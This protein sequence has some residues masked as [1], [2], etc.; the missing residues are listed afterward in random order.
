MIQLNDTQKDLIRRCVADGCS[1]TEIQK[2]LVEEFKLSVT[3]M[4]LRFIVLDMGLEI[5]DRASKAA[6]DLSK[7]A[8]AGSA[9]EPDDDLPATGGVEVTL[10]RIIKPGAVVSGTV[11][12]SDG[13]KASWMLDQLGRLA[14]D[15]GKAN[16]RP[17]AQ[18]VQEFQEQ[19][20]N[21]L[22]GR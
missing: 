22:Q 10:D 9:T 14:L 19:L 5:K 11:V 21:L 8:T 7:A 17:S 1:L 16:Y 6:V 18:D 2:K 12:F 3:F 4:D 15:A 20:R 13:V